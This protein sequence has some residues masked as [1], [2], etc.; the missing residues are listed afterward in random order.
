MI[1]LDVFACG[2]AISCSSCLANCNCHMTQPHV[3]TLG[4]VLVQPPKEGGGGGGAEKG[5]QM[6][7]L[8]HCP[9]VPMTMGTEGTGR[10]SL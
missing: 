7:T 5:A 9:I 2:C 4:G 8:S 3:T 1:S 6:S 10:K